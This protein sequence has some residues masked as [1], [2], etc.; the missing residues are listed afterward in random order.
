MILRQLRD[1]AEDIEAVRHVATAAFTVL[2]AAMGDPPEPE[3]TPE[4]HAREDSLNRHF[5][6]HDQQ[7]CWIAHDAEGRPAGAA[8]ASR[9]EDTWGLS[10]LVVAPGAQGKGIG[11]ALLERTLAYGEGCSRGIIS[12][13]RDPRAAR[14]YWAA[15]FALH[16]GMRLQGQVDPS[17]LTGPDGPV[18]EGGPR[19]RDLMDGVD[20]Q[21]RGGAHGPDHDELLR[22][23]R[24][25]TADDRA[26]R[27]YCYV[28]MSPGGIHLMGLSATTEAVAGRLLTAALRDVPAGATVK[29]PNVTAE[30]R[31][32]VDIALTA[33]LE[34]A[35][36]GY[37]CL[38]GM[39]P[40][41]GFVPSGQFL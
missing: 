29:I 3:P 35:H 14:A 12:G 23:H 19:H 34:P 5:V 20:R 41:V 30:Q 33:G 40:P 24:L 21:L 7:G 22:H 10:L 18:V 11:R 17:R 31:W 4:Q 38:R 9:R 13:S 2:H 6:R 37:L 32:A 39:R 36:G 28:D 25:L 16:P 27:G 26:G 15:G 1:T 8:L